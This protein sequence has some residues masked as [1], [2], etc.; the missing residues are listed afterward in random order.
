MMSGRGDLAW[1]TSAH[2][3]FHRA[4]LVAQIWHWAH[5]CFVVLSSLNGWQGRAMAGAK[6]CFYM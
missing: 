6:L 2:V 3:H 1:H 4:R 5:C